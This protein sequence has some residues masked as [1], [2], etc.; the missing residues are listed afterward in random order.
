MMPERVRGL[1]SPRCSIWSNALSSSGSP[2]ASSS[3]T[4]LMLVGPLP[5]RSVV[6]TLVRGPV[7]RCAFIAVASAGFPVAARYTPGALP[8]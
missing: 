8:P 7:A 1:A 6:T 2:A 3:G 5:T 4:S